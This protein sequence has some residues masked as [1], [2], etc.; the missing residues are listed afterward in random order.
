MR[1]L[2][3]A[4]THGVVW[5]TSVSVFVVLGGYFVYYYLYYLYVRAGGYHSFTGVVVR[6]LCYVTPWR[7]LV[8]MALFCRGR[9]HAMS[10]TA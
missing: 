4:T 7:L 8:A 9:V 1:L 10:K 5:R 3:L 6:W 2:V